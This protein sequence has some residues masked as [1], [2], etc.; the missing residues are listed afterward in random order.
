MSRDAIAR[1]RGALAGT[2]AAGALLSTQDNIFYA[3]AFASVMDGWHLMEPIAAV[4]VPTD[5]ALPVVLILPEASI[6][7]VIVSQRGGY[8]VHYDRL[9]TFDMLN[10]CE[11]ARAEDAH[12]ALPEDLLAE[13]GPVMEQVE[14]QCE[15]DIIQT[16]AATLAR[17]LSPDDRVLFDDL[18]VAARVHSVSH[19]Q[20]GDALEVMLGARAVKTPA[21]QRAHRRRDHGLYR[22]TAR[23]WQ[24]LVRGRKSGGAL[25]DR[26]R[27]RS[28]ARKPHAVRRRL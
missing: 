23:R 24:E 5:S 8:P 18:R 19:Q 22:L 7:S 21:A 3:S 6:I 9:A 20:T 14:G 26:P 11:T 13:L 1:I 10:F 15:Q 28:A 25:Y 16:I 2:D 4:F 12:L 27:R 17:H